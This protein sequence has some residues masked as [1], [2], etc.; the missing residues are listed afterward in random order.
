MQ[1]S[2]VSLPVEHTSMQIDDTAIDTAAVDPAAATAA[3]ALAGL[4][5]ESAAAVAAAGQLHAWMV[6]WIPL[7]TST[8]YTIGCS[9]VLCVLSC[10][11]PAGSQ[12]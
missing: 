10:R 2:A 8:A 4:A 5:T 3:A 7:D 6:T 12:W 9:C 11:C 1:Q